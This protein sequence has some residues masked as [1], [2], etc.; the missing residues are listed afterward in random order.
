MLYLMMTVVM[1][2]NVLL[3]ISPLPLFQVMNV[4]TFD[5][6]TKP[7][8]MAVIS[9]PSATVMTYTEIKDTPILSQIDIRG[10]KTGSE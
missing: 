10:K 4:P 8:D 3:L 7:W 9:S 2:D 1:V 5:V 6:G